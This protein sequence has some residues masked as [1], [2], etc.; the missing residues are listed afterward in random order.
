LA[1][2]R[3]AGFATSV[4]APDAARTT[5]VLTELAAATLKGSKTA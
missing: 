4:M 2:V 5:Q 3:L 1:G